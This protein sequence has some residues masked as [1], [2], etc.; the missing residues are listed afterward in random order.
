MSLV[1]PFLKPLQIAVNRYLDYDP[2]VPKQLA[3]ME[4]RVIELH[5]QQLELSLYMIIS[6]DG[7][8]IRE[9][10]EGKADATISG[11]PL[12][13]AMM[14]IQSSTSSL[15]SGD[16]V[17]EGDT[18]LAAQFQTFLKAIEVDWEEPL[19]KITGDVLAHQFGN[20][21]RDVSGWVRETT[22]TTA[23]NASEYVREEQNI[24]PSKFEV[25]KFKV[26]VDDL[27]LSVERL[28][29]KV[30]RLMAAK[31]NLENDSKRK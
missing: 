5:F 8:D 12:A 9:V 4:G 15:L 16:V 29:A 18:E 17:I 11:T 31:L 25:N 1:S 19:S 14:N 22:K 13:L 21:V 30:Q 26:G 24:L 7:L 2:E 10:F 27:R 6:A 23:I 28:E 3:R 20:L